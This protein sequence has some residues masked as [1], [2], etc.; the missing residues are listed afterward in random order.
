MTSGFSLEFSNTNMFE[1]STTWNIE[2]IQINIWISCLQQL[3]KRTYGINLILGSKSFDHGILRQGTRVKLCKTIMAVRK[4]IMKYQHA[5]THQISIYN[6]GMLCFYGYI[7]SYMLID[8][9]I[10]LRW[11]LFLW[12]DHITSS[13]R[14][15]FFRSTTWTDR[16]I[17]RGNSCWEWR[18]DFPSCKGRG[19]TYGFS[20][21][22]ESQSKNYVGFFM[23]CFQKFNTI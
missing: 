20:K 2:Y 13:K 14:S 16:P 17:Y 7:H 6:Y 18:W 3:K 1:T 15:P 4:E 9:D 22:L 12:K 10:P 21:M 11:I 8:S 5:N 23:D 19:E